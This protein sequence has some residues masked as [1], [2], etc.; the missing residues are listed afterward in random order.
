VKAT[1]S[2]NATLSSM[3]GETRWIRRST[4]FPCVMA[5]NVFRPDVYHRLAEAFTE[6]LR[7]AEGRSYLKAHDIHG[8][9]ITADVAEMLDPL[10][11]RPWHDLLARALGITAT[12][13]VACGLHHHRIGSQHGF[14]HNDLNPGWFA[15]TAGPDE[16]VVGGPEVEYTTGVARQPGVVPVESVRAAS[17][18]FYLAN[19]PWEPG[20]GGATGLYTSGADDIERPAVAMPPV[21]N[22]LLAFECTP[23]SYHGF[24]S[25]RRR[26]RNSIVMWLH[27]TKAEVVSR[28]GADAIVPYGRMP[29]KERAT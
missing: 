6:L 28:W 22:A 8:C 10:V 2:P 11:S 12:G 20:D 17:V 15:R 21:N 16:L 29:H 14:P 5:Y 23:R 3:L 19:P 13:Q 24:I 26:P 18:L 7:G 1:P 4:P 27:R 25:N 9:S